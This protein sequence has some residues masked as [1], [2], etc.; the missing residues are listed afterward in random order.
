MRSQVKAQRDGESPSY[1]L[2]SE[3][4]FRQEQGWYFKTREGIN[5]GPFGC[6]FD[7][8]VELESLL[9]VLQECVDEK[10]IKLVHAQAV[11]ANANDYLL[12]SPAY[13]NYLVGEGGVELL[14]A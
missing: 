8:E 6:R 3:R 13:T 9:R 5:V 11:N 10:A 14:S 12:S 7:A 2:R 4:I 1:W